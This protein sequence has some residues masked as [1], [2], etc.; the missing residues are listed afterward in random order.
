MI[1]DTAGTEIGFDVAPKPPAP[2]RFKTNLLLSADQIDILEERCQKRISELMDE[3]GLDD[4][5]NVNDDSWMGRRKVY[6]DLFD[7]SQ[8]WRETKYGGVFKDSNLTLGTAQRFVREMH[9]KCADDLLGT[10]PFFA[11]LKTDMGDDSTARAVE[12]LV[13]QKVDRSDIQNELRSIMRSAIIRNECVTKIRYVKRSTPYFGPATVMIDGAGN[14]VI[15]PNGLLIYEDDDFLPDP[16]VEGLFRL[17]KDPLFAMVHGQYQHRSFPRLEQELVNY[18]GVE[19]R[20]VD[21]RSFLCPLRC[22]CVHEADFLAQLYDD[23]PQ[24]IREMYGEYDGFDDYWNSLMTDMGSGEM[25]AKETHGENAFGTPSAINVFRRMAECYV[26]MDIDGDQKEEEVF[27]VFDRSSGKVVFWEY[28]ANLM[29]KRP[30]EIVPGVGRVAN[31]WYGEGV[32]QAVIDQDTYID[33]Q[34]NRFNVK[35]SREAS[36]TFRDPN[37]VREWRNG[38]QVELG[39][40]KVYDVEPGYDKENRPPIWR[41]N[42]TEKSEIGME[43]MNLAQ[44]QINSMFGIISA[45][46]ASQTNMNQSR[47]ATGIL[48]IERTANLLVK[49]SEIQQQHS[50]I[51]IM[52]QVVTLILENLRDTE[53]LMSKDGKMLLTINRSEARTI[54]REI[55]LLLTRS[56]S[57]ELLST[58]QQALAI[59][60]DY[61]A[62]RDAS[63]QMAR[64]QRPLVLA[65][66]K[67]L[68]VSDPDELCPVITDEEIQAWQE[69]QAELAKGELKRA[70]RELINYKDTPWTIQEQWEQDAGWQPAPLEERM[71]KHTFENPPK[72]EPEKKPP[73]Q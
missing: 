73:A 9:S 6:Q 17:K 64:I 15:T 10:R 50:M 40:D 2:T 39:T 69:R 12:E 47:T 33:C 38:E 60:N 42:L 14:P 28:L 3:M 4:S 67:A 18:E 34:F 26:R 65:M 24:R 1:N 66:L 44:Q 19:V 27:C 52:E 23:T 48:N 30:F 46:D 68:E 56:R 54:H 53:L 62:K 61:L 25:Q 70:T 58:N 5:G 31:R 72:P 22:P 41:I 45:K 49:N 51:K 29:P 59:S 71:Q 8:D 55:R 57:S 16:H 20:E 11:A 7:N 43:L 37:A 63:P 21:Y 32:V 13:Q 35:D 36:I